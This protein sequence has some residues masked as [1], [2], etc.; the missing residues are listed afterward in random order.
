M[1]PIKSLRTS[2]WLEDDQEYLGRSL[3]KVWLL[4][5]E[6]LQQK[7][8]QNLTDDAEIT[9]A[10][11]NRELFQE[12]ITGQIDDLFLWDWEKPPA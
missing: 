3:E 11:I 9:A 1:V 8:Q 2:N 7:P 10:A 12:Q 6:K 5:Q 4:L